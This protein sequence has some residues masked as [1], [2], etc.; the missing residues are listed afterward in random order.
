MLT[1]FSRLSSEHDR[2]AKHAG[3][4]VRERSGVAV[5]PDEEKERRQGGRCA[6]VSLS[7]R[8][9]GGHFSV[10]DFCLSVT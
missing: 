3:G 5:G 2:H 4:H 8:S 10:F 9:D 6:P 1:F 7:E